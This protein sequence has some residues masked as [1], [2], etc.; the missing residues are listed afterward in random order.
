MKDV[1]SFA[2]FYINILYSERNILCFFSEVS[3]S[4]LERSVVDVLAWQRLEELLCPPGPA[5]APVVTQPLPAHALLCPLVPDSHLQDWAVKSPIPSYSSQ[6][7]AMTYRIIRIG[8][9]KQFMW[10][11]DFLCWKKAYILNSNKL[12]FF[13][14]NFFLFKIPY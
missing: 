9:G 11:C 3:L 5:P 10:I 8:K 4:Q 13:S 7:V 6:P 14:F 2:M 12:Y 1:Q